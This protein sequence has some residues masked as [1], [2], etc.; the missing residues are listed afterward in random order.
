MTA[1]LVMFAVAVAVIVIVMF[2]ADLAGN[3]A[4]CGSQGR[5]PVTY[6]R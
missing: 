5:V 1:R 4:P 2:A 6:C 3:R